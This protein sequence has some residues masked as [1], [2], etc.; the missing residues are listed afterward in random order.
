MFQAILDRIGAAHR[1][2]WSGR[3]QRVARGEGTRVG[4]IGLLQLNQT[5]TAG[6]KTLADSAN[7]L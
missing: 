3:G 4:G 6:G 5:I 1:R 7:F 2:R